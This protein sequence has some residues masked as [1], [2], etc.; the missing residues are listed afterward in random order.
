MYRTKEES[1]LSWHQD[2]PQLS[3]QLLREFCATDGGIIDVGGGTS[4]LARR[5]LAAGYEHV[6]V[7]DISA[8]AIERAKQRTGEMADRVNWIVADVTEAHDLGTFDLWHDRAVFHFMTA[9]EDR[10]K[11]VEAVRRAL[12]IGGHAIIGGFAPDGPEQCSNLPVRRI[13]E[14]E[15]AA[16]FGPE[17]A[18][19]RAVRERH[20]TPWGKAQ[21]FVYVVLQRER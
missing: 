10:A 6:A 4:L 16:A 15:L 21:A 17:F 20:I 3:F 13:D 14:R 1:Q 18:M 8:S 19:V 9:A 7:L 5:A 12:A 11:Y 2:E